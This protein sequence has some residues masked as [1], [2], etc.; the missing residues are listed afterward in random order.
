MATITNEFPIIANKIKRALTLQFMMAAV[1]SD[2]FPSSSE[3]FA[4][5]FL[6][7]V[8]FIMRRLQKGLQVEMEIILLPCFSCALTCLAFFSFPVLKEIIQCSLITVIV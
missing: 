6:K 1:F 8:L 7:K 2:V 3:K 5:S 4:L